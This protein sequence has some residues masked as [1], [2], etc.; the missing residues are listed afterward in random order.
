MM[1]GRSRLMMLRAMTKPVERQRDALGRAKQRRVAYC[2]GGYRAV[3]GELFLQ[4]DFHFSGCQG[5]EIQGMLNPLCMVSL[6]H[7]IASHWSSDLGPASMRAFMRPAPFCALQVWPRRTRKRT[8]GEGST[9]GK[10]KH[11]WNSNAWSMAMH[12]FQ[13]L[14]SV[15]RSVVEGQNE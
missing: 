6:K 1:M 9:W 14:A 2:V 7:T 12:A 13:D 15:A 10:G 4:L 3:N 5:T 11:G 8:A